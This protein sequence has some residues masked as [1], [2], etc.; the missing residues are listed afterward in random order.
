MTNFSNRHDRRQ[1]ESKR[2]AQVIKRNARL[3]ALRLKKRFQ[4]SLGVYE[5]LMVLIDWGAADR[6]R[7]CFP[8][9]ETLHEA[10]GV[11]VRTLQRAVAML[12]EYGL[13]DVIAR[14][15]INGLGINRQT[16][17]LY[18]FTDFFFRATAENARGDTLCEQIDNKIK[19]KKEKG[20]WSGM[21]GRFEERAQ[22]VRDIGIKAPAVAKGDE[23]YRMMD[24]RS[25]RAKIDI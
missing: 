17:N 20:L 24:W 5:A 2:R 8:S 12:K 7:A 19:N 21:W 6:T 23:Y 13:L 18:R 1:A 3:F 22:P 9:M 10:S 14:F 11:C 15:E 25:C 16:T 4:L